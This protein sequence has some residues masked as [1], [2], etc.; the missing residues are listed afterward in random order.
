MNAWNIAYL[1]LVVFGLGVK[2]SL[3]GQEIKGKHNFW[4]T[5]ILTAISLFM[6][7]KAGLFN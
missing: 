3:H 6:L 4:T 1:I 2:A 5:V 7:Y